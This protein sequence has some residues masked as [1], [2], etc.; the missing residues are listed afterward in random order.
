MNFIYCI[1]LASSKCN[2]NINFNNMHKLGYLIIST[3]IINLNLAVV[4]FRFVNCNCN[5]KIPSI[6]E[7]LKT[8]PNYSKQQRYINRR[9]P[10]VFR[11]Y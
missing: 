11:Y 10:K 1:T 4:Q 6:T 3:H 7:N 5:I 8:I 2:M 9:Q